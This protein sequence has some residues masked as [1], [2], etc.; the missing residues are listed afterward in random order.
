MAI[1]TVAKRIGTLEPENEWNRDKPV[2]FVVPRWQPGSK[3][4]PW[5]S[6]LWEKLPKTRDLFTHSS[7]T[8]W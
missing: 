4:S 5:P 8:L 1:G 2:A 7:T 6:Y 3:P